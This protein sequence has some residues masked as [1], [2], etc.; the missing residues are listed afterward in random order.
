MYAD[1]SIY[2]YILLQYIFSSTAQTCVS[3]S[4][5]W[6]LVSNVLIKKKCICSYFKELMLF[7]KTTYQF[8]LSIIPSHIVYVIVYSHIKCILYRFEKKRNQILRVP[9]Q[10]H[11]RFYHV[12]IQRCSYIFFSKSSNNWCMFS[13]QYQTSNN[14]KRYHCLFC[15]YFVIKN[16]SKEKNHAEDQLFILLLFCNKENIKKKIML[17]NKLE[18]TR[19]STEWS[20]ITFT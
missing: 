19:D 1:N 10:Y 2:L 13:M 16:T 18:S 9:L 12:K 20:K 4:I 7:L 3:V 15:F 14:Y 17:T 11:P 5:K 6:D 8:L